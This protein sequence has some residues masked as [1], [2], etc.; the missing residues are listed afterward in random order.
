MRSLHLTIAVTASL[1]AIGCAELETIPGAVCGNLIIDPGEES[2]VPMKAL[3]G[4]NREL[5]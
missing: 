2:I 1:L 4:T 5:T 3:Y